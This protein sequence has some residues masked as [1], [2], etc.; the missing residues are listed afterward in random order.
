MNNIILSVI[1]PDYRQ[2]GSM[3]KINI[4]II[5]S[6]ENNDIISI[7]SIEEFNNNIDKLINVDEK[8]YKNS[9]HI[10]KIR[11]YFNEFY[12]GI[13]K[14]ANIDKFDPNTSFAFYK[15]LAK[16]G[17]VV[18]INSE[19]L[20]LIYVPEILKDSQKDSLSILS[21]IINPNSNNVLF[22]CGKKV[23]TIEG[24]NYNEVLKRLN[25]N[26]DNQEMRM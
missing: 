4:D 11:K 6:K 14:T 12:P 25:I 8:D 21:K 18:Y 1:I 13:A 20:S 16:N 23:E 2:K 26:T 19:Y 10:E 24:L 9:Y 5:F 22:I 17:F 3:G 15:I 7:N